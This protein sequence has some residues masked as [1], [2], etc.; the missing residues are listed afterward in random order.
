MCGEERVAETDEPSDDCSDIGVSLHRQTP[1]T[2]GEGVATYVI[3]ESSDPKYTEGFSRAWNG[4]E[5]S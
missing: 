3:E 4:W 1:D 2:G 5:N